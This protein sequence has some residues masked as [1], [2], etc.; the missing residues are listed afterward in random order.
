M[1]PKPHGFSRVFDSLLSLNPGVAFMVPFKPL[2]FHI[3]RGQHMMP[4]VIS[5]GCDSHRLSSE[6]FDSLR[7]NRIAAES[8]LG[9]AEAVELT[10]LGDRRFRWLR[11][12][13]RKTGDS[14]IAIMVSRRNLQSVDMQIHI[15]RNVRQLK[16]MIVFL[17]VD[18][19]EQQPAATAAA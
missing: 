12:L 11:R 4:N 7:L 17:C 1:K 6:V 10:A 19:P 3:V 8:Q 16:A 14:D 9:S 15:S 2:L 13:R 5:G 18:L